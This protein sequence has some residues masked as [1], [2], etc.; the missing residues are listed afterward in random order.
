MPQFIIPEVS[1]S[2]TTTQV[3]STISERKPI[4]KQTSNNI[5]FGAYIYFAG[6]PTREPTSSKVIHFILQAYTGIGQIQAIESQ[7]TIWF[8]RIHDARHFEVGWEEM[9]LNEP[10]RQKSYSL[11]PWQ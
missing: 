5:C 6:P 10:A 1:S 4:K 7:L 8:T 9:M 11:N 3:L 2:Q